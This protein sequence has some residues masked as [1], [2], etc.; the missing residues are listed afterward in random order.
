MGQDSEED[1]SLLV[2]HLTECLKTTD[3]LSE[4]GDTSLDSTDLSEEHIGESIWVT[5]ETLDQ[6]VGNTSTNENCG[7]VYV[8]LSPEPAP[9]WVLH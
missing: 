6:T 1:G 8:S 3:E 4:K 5:S 2:K 9:T 7:G